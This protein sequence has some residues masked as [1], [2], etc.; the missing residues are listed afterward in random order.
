MDILE[1]VKQYL[2]SELRLNLSDEKTLITNAQND[3]A[4][5]LSTKFQ[6]RDHG[7]FRRMNGFLVRNVREIRLTAPIDKITKK[8]TVNGFL[9]ENEP[10]PR[11][12]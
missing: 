4:L 12:L 5:F 8:L 6:R 1:K 11:F 10:S 2:K 3:S 9:K 7:S